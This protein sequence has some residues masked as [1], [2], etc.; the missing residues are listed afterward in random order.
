MGAH[1]GFGGSVARGSITCPFH[2]FAFDTEGRCVRV[3]YPG[4]TP[5]KAT[6]ET[7]PLVLHDGAFLAWFDAAG[8]AP[9][10]HVPKEPDRAWSP[11]RYHLFPGLRAH[12]QETSENSVDFGHL[13]AVHKYRDVRIVEGM[14]TEG[15]TLTARYQ[16]RRETTSLG[17]PGGYVLANFHVRVH[18]LGYSIVDVEMPEW[19]LHTQQLVCCTP[20]DGDRVDIRIGMRWRH[21]ALEALP[22]SWRRALHRLA[23]PRMISAFAQDVAQD[24]DIWENKSYTH[25]PRLARGDGPIGAYRAWAAQF[26][27][28]AADVPSPAPSAAAG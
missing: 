12:P 2:D 19:G 28:A 18:G 17:L 1:L 16:M 14:Q 10:F 26:Y 11:W 6:L 27:P 3:P 8:R 7:H 5:P 20:L 25:P 15:A 21:P 23:L 13:T 9:W 22:P 24:V 4:G